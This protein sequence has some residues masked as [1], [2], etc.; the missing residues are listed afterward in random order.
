LCTNDSG[1]FFLPW[2]APV[3]QTNQVDQIKNK[4][5]QVYGETKR[6]KELR[7]KGVAGSKSESPLLA[8][9]CENPWLSSF[10]HETFHLWVVDHHHH[11]HLHGTASRLLCIIVCKVWDSR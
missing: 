7:A 10:G 1:F 8:A 9:A 3:S 6:K 11:G 4:Y 2:P 5:N